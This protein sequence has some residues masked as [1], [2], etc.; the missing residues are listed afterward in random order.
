VRE[1]N[2]GSQKMIR[3][4]KLKEILVNKK[5]TSVMREILIPKAIQFEGNRF[6]GIS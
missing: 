1:G 3:K 2:E 6:D 5:R 4:V